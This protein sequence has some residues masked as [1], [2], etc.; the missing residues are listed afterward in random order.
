MENILSELERF[1]GVRG[2]A[3]VS[4]DGLIVHS[5]LPP[6]LDPDAVSGM[7]ATVFRNGITTAKVLN[8]GKVRH[9]LIETD[10]D[11]IIFSNIGNGFLA[12][13]ST[14]KINLGLLRIKIDKA[15]KEIK[16]KLIEE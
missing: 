10:T 13:I 4:N 16:E 11:F 2:V 15:V 5:L 3:I 7:C 6:D 14:R 9:I 12:V 1:D 8:S